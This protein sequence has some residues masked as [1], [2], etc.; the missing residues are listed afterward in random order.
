[1]ANVAKDN[2]VRVLKDW[3]KTGLLEVS[4]SGM[5]VADF[6]KLQDNI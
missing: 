4:N 1:M 6:Q 3:E 2:V 5:R